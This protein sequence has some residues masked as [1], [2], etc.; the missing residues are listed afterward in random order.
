MTSSHG[1]SNHYIK[2][3]GLLEKGEKSKCR[4]LIWQDYNFV[5]P[6]TGKL[7]SDNFDFSP[8]SINPLNLIPANI[9]DYAVYVHR[10][11]GSLYDYKKAYMMGLCMYGCMSLWVYVCMYVCMGVCMYVWVYV[12]MGVCM[13]GCM[14]VC[15]GVCMYVWKL[16]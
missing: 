15:M 8:F 14:G 7:I 11:Y 3:S 16:I 4:I 9:S 6:V 10:V 2:F 12:C 13:Y 5:G 1:I